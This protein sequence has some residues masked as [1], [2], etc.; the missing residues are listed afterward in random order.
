MGIAENILE[1]REG[2]PEGVTL[3]S[4]SKYQPVEALQE[5]YAAGERV[6][7]ESRAQEM[8]EKYNILPKDIEWHM[9]GHLQTNKVKYIAPF[10][11]L[12]H[13][14]DSLELLSQ[15]N[16]SAAK[17]DRVIDCLIQLHVAAEE[18][19]FGFI[20]G[21]ASLILSSEEFKAMKHVRI[22]GVMGMAT[23][24]D[25]MERVKSDFRAIK[26]EYDQLKERFFAQCDYFNTIS[27]GM[28]GDYQIAINEGSTMIRIGTTIFGERKK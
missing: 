16:K 25:D 18:S 3:V 5:A 23:H 8:A 10:V 2:I 9:I 6:F 13:S 20:P 26:G 24:T 19:K 17:S 28:S 11:S 12:I 27:M 1:I 21:E 15:I 4:V 22:R 7:G 14:V